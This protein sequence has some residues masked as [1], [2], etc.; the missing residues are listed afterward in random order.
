[1]P[2]QS[3]VL[4]S[5]TSGGVEMAVDEI[6]GHFGGAA[7]LLKESGDV[8]IKVNAVDSKPHC[9]TTPEVLQAVVRAFKDAGANTVYVLENCTQGNITRLVYRASGLYDACKK[10]G[11]VPV[12]L[13]E[14]GGMPVYLPGLESFVDFSD[15]V[16]ERLIKDRDRNLY[17]SLPRLKTHSM[18]QVTLAVK[19][20]FGFVHQKDRIPDHNFKLHQKFADIF[21]VVRP[22]FVIVD[23]TTATNH[24]HY[25]AE[26]YAEECVLPTKVLIAG[27]DPLAV[28]VA[29]SAFMG[30]SLEDVPHLALAARNG[31]GESDLEKIPIVGRELFNTR[32]VQLTHMLLDRF[33]EDLTI[34]RGRERCC[35]EGCRR[36]TETLV[37][38]L[39]GDYDGKG[40]FTI[41]MGKGVDPSA[42]EKL[43][44]RVHL[45][46]SCAIGDWSAELKKRLGKKNVTESPGCNNLSASIHGLTKQMGVNPLK[47]VPLFVPSALFHLATAKAKGSRAL[48]PPLF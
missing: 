45:A 41:L 19:N 48:V 14:T 44:G 4:F 28:D 26:K 2:E 33:P 23:G 22:D 25:I 46:G 13:D 1:M 20:Q 42:V 35:M 40:G 43:T 31:T 11:A 3:T 29:A 9:Y 21:R 34:L 27:A 7:S 38:V 36:N 47:L 24:G 30:F 12:Y 5:D 10:T 8:Y 32:K 15:F 18:S 39:H 6:F 16:V 17:V 37:E